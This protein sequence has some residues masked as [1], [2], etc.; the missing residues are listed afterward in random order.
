MA[1]A[2]ISRPEDLVD[3]I[4]DL[5]ENS[6]IPFSFVSRHDES[7]TPKYPCVQVQAAGL[8]RTLHGTHTFGVGLRSYIYIM[9]ADLN[10]S[11]RARTRGDL[12]LATQVV[13]L[14]EN[15]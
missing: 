15:K 10:V 14:L 2:T 7:L 4:A 11:R 13:N 9:H 6:T 8:D 3:K 12:E 1:V 5:L